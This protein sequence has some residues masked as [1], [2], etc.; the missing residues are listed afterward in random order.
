MKRL[1]F[2]LAL[3]AL[4]TPA[5]ALEIGAGVVT[6][7]ETGEV[8]PFIGAAGLLSPRLLS[9]TTWAR[10]GDVQIIDTSVSITVCSFG[11]VGVA[12]GGGTGIG[13]EKWDSWRP[14]LSCGVTLYGDVLGFI[15]RAGWAR[16]REGGGIVAE[17]VYYAGLYLSR[18]D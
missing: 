5:L 14:T 6:F 2:A 7:S 11:A 1:L 13:W 17:N 4:G 8:A 18:D 3:L 16:V 15:G 9:V 10:N 12:F